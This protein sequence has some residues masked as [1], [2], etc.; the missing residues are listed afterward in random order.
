MKSAIETMIG[1][2]VLTLMT[3]MGASFI[4][5]SISTQKAQNYHTTVVQELENS[6]FSQQ[7]I[8][9]TVAKAKDNGYMNIKVEVFRNEQTD[10]SYAKVSLPYSYSIPVLGQEKNNV[11]VG[12]AR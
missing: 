9:E 7:V 5:A 12:Y 6:N 1:I 8:N 3:V 10:A 11:I 2:I 4:T